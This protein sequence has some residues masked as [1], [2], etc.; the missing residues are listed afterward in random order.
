MR[1]AVSELSVLHIVLQQRFS[2]M[3]FGPLKLMVNRGVFVLV[4]GV[5]LVVVAYAQQNLLLLFSLQSFYDA[6]VGRLLFKL[7]REDLFEH[8]SDAMWYHLV[9]FLRVL[10]LQSFQEEV[11]EFVIH[12]LEL[13]LEVIPGQR[14]VV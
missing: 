1:T 4:L 6:V 10:D 8:G 7:E 9:D 11:L 12:V 2:C 5:A 3:V 13:L 14:V